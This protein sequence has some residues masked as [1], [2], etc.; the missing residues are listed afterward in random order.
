MAVS[1]THLELTCG[2]LVGEDGP[3]VLCA[4]ADRLNRRAEGLLP[5]FHDDEPGSWE[6]YHRALRRYRA[7]VRTS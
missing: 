6:T 2:C 4:I 7:H 1:T 3:V 5:P